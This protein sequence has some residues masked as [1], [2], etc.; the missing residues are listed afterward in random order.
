MKEKL[1]SNKG[2][3]GGE[4]MMDTSATNLTL[5]HIYLFGRAISVSETVTD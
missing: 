2:E 5:S 1:L 3:V 4:R